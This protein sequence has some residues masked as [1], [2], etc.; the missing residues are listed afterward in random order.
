MEHHQL[1]LNL[2]FLVLNSFLIPFSGVK[3]I[4]ELFSV[5]IGGLEEG[6]VLHLDVKAATMICDHASTMDGIFA[7]KY[8]LNSTFL[9]NAN[10][11]M[12]LPQ[13]F[14]SWWCRKTAV[15]ARQRSEA[16][17]PGPF[18]F[19][20]WYA[21]TL[22]V[23]FLGICVG[24]L[25]PSIVFVATPFFLLKCLVDK[26]NIEAEV[27]ELQT[28][29][30]STLAAQVVSWMR[31]LVGFVWI[32]SGLVLYHS[33]DVFGASHTKQPSDAVDVY[34]ILGICLALSGFA[35]LLWSFIDLKTILYRNERGLDYRGKHLDL[36]D[37][38][39]SE[40]LLID[41]EEEEERPLTWNVCMHHDLVDD[42]LQTPCSEGKFSER[43]FIF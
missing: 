12:D 19:G 21:W 18:T 32:G 14:A 25:V 3:S 15:T 2:F 11:L 5:W 6:N 34:S 24:S 13:G 23:Y 38:M 9:S 29:L 26:W 17:Q 10:Q 41:C 31:C 7:I 16:N 43:G 37:S 42:S 36:I 39:A 33:E 20:Y 35:V 27:Y 40:K 22:S 4:L 8:L 30:D 28:E 1:S